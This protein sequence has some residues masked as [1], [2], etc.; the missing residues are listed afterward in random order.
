MGLRLFPLASSYKVLKFGAMI[1]ESIRTYTNPVFVYLPPHAELRG[2]A[3]VVIDPAINPD[4]MEL[5]CSPDTCRGGVLEPEGTVEIKYRT[6]DLL[7]TINRLDDEC[8]RLS[9]EIKARSTGRQQLLQPQQSSGSCNATATTPASSS[10]LKEGHSPMELFAGV[11]KFGAMIVES[12][13]TYTNPVFV[14]LPPHAEL[15]GGA[16]VVID[17]AIN[18]DNMELFCSPDTCRGGVLEPEGTVEI[19]Y[20]TADLLATI[21]RLDDEC[22]RLSE[23]IKARSTGRQQLLQPQQSSGTCNATA[24]TS[25]SSSTLKGLQERLVARQHLLLPIYQQV[26][27]RFADLHDTPGRMTARGLVHGTVDWRSS[28]AFFFARLSR[29]LLELEAVRLLRQAQNPLNTPD[30]VPPTPG[31]RCSEENDEEAEAEV[32]WSHQDKGKVRTRLWSRAVD[33]RLRTSSDCESPSS[34]MPLEVLGVPRSDLRELT[35]SSELNAEPDAVLLSDAERACYLIAQ[36][37]AQRSASVRRDLTRLRRWFIQDHLSK[38]TLE[39]CLTFSGA[40]ACNETVGD[41]IAP[42]VFSLADVQPSASS[43]LAEAVR[44]WETSDATVARWLAIQL[45]HPD[46]CQLLENFNAPLLVAG[47]WTLVAASE[48]GTVDAANSPARQPPKSSLMSRLQEISK[49]Q[50]VNHIKRLLV[51]HPECISEALECVQHLQNAS[52]STAAA[53]STTAPPRPVQTA[54]RSTASRP[55]SESPA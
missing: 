55:L 40:T 14:Y 18:P 28:R 10:T 3:W 44:A 11:L 41:S 4:N 31:D 7:A 15:R 39:S 30:A 22:H 29:R 33:C 6:A 36:I 27:H 19:K 42:P 38:E 51:S 16:W 25:A 17:P 50:M 53:S 37:G 8:R 52:A 26:A 43:D 1:V 46:L 13:R 48:A 2:G 54:C 47:C 24:T 23:E 45:E 35:H 12:L 34:R 5:F 32:R 9:E 20:R 49:Q 21:N